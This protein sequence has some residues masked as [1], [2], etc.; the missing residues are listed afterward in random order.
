MVIM[1]P[2]N[3]TKPLQI[4]PRVPRSGDVWRA[5]LT[6]PWMS[7]AVASGVEAF[8]RA[9]AARKA[10]IAKDAAAAA[11]AVAAAAAKK[12]P[13]TSTAPPGARSMPP[14]TP[15]SPIPKTGGGLPPP[16]S[17]LG[18]GSPL[19]RPSTGVVGGGGMA[20]ALMVGVALLSGLR[21]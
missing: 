13:S 20:M 17:P 12:L 2:E 8:L 6:A 5:T 14:I 1:A 7:P 16:G 11:A 9:E 4:D 15:K 18:S 3:G 21:R 10:Q 19:P